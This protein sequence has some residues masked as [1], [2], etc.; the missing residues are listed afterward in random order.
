[1]QI[2]DKLAYLRK[3][4]K[5]S[6]DELAKKLNTSRSSIAM[7]ESNAR[8]PTTSTLSRYSNLFDVSVDYLL[9]NETN[10]S[11]DK[12][13]VP[14]YRAV[15]CGNP[16]IADEDIID[17]EEI[18]PKLKTQGDH[19]GLRLKGQSMEPNFKE[20][21]VVIVRKQSTVDSGDIAIVRVNG[22]EATMKIV[23]KSPEGVT[24]IATNTNV[25]LPKFYNNYEIETVPVEI[26]GKVIE[27]RRKF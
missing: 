9:G 23:E 7:Y 19:F 18:S 5:Y 1:M 17:F 8:T 11:N 22:D 10:T 13:E 14:V 20:G 24:L 16:F 3:S 25:F 6:Q 27:Q 21:D 26:I 12:Y 15:S 2:G 4:A